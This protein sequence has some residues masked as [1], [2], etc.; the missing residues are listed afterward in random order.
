MKSLWTR[1]SFF[2]VVRITRAGKR[3]IVI[4]VPVWIMEEALD[5]L[6]DLVWLVEVTVFRFR[7]SFIYSL[8]AKPAYA[9]FLM[10]LSPSVALEIL[11]EVIKELRRHG[12]FRMVEVEDAENKIYI[13]LY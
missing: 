6:A 9:K 10:N 4:P 11:Q 1:P 13:D 7:K 3:S 2:L 8:K 12:R 5:T